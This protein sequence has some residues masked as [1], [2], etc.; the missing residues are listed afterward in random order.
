MSSVKG[1][2]VRMISRVAFPRA[3]I[4]ATQRVG[5]FQ[6]LVLRCEVSKPAAGTKLQPLLPSDDTRTYTPIGASEGLVL[7]GW[8]HAG[9]PGARWMSGARPGEVLPFVG[10]QRS[11]ALDAGPVVLVGDETSVAVAA[12]FAV[13]RPGALH[14]IIQAEGAADVRGAAESVGLSQIEV[15]PRGD[16]TATVAAV[17]ESLSSIPNAVVALTGGSEL[18]VTVREA[19]RQAGVRNIKTKTYWSPGKTGLD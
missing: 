13:E 16:T 8:T 1:K 18:V 12:S 9:G 19:L 3:T 15:V 6:R 2:L 7:L 5:G 4:A 17:H 14:A 11:L 10:P